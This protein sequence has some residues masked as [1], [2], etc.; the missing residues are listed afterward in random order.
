MQVRRLEIIVGKIISPE[1]TLPA[2]SL[3]PMTVVGSSCIEQ[4]FITISIMPAKVILPVLLS[5]SCMAFIPL[6]VAALPSPKIFD[7]MFIAIYLQAVLLSV[8]NKKRIKGCNNFASLSESPLLSKIFI[9]PNHTEYIP[10]KLMH[11]STALAEEFNK[12][13]IIASGFVKINIMTETSII[14][15]QII[16]I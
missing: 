6:G 5:S 2:L 15:N 11:N 16:A 7:D 1:E 10:H 13:D 4:E 3:S 14:K 8:L 12:L 9:K